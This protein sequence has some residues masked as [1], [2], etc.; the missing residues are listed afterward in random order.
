MLAPRVQDLFRVCPRSGRI[1]GLRWRGRA[2]RWLFPLVGVMALVWHLVRVLPKPGRALYPCQRVAGPLAWAFA[3]YVVSFVTAVVAFHRARRSFRQARYGLAVAC[4]VVA[5]GAAILHLNV[6]SPEAEAAPWIPT[7][8]PNTPIG[9]A[10]GI[11]AGRVVWARDPSACSWNGS[12]GYWWTTNSTDQARVDGLLSH[13]LRRLT[14]DA[15]DAAAWE[16][17]FRSYNATHGNGD[18]GYA[19]GQAV[20][21]KINQ[22]TARS[23]H[24]LNGNTGDQNSINGSPQLILSLLRQLVNEAGV[25][26][27]NLYVYD[28]SRYIADSIFVPCHAEFPQV[29][30]VEVE[31][32]GTEG[33]EAVPPESQWTQNAI[34]YSDPTRA[35]GRHLPPFITSASYLINM[36][37]MKDHGAQ[38]PTLCAKNHYGTIHGLNHGAI[39]PAGM[40]ESNPMVDMHASPYLGERTML[41][42]IDTLY[43]AD[44]PDARPSKWKSQ[45]FGTNWP[46]SVF[47]S[48]DGVAIESVGFDFINAEWGVDPFTDNLMHEAALADNPP[49]GKTYGPKSLG[50]HEHWNNATDMRYSRDLGGPDGIELARVFFPAAP[51]TVLAAPGDGRVDLR[52]SAGFG[53]AAYNV[54]RATSPGGPYTLLAGLAGTTY[55]D[56]GVVNGSAYYYVVSA[57]NDL[58]E[59]AASAEISATPGA[60]VAAINCGGAAVAQFSADS[61]FVG[62]AVG[63]ATTAFIETDGLASAAPQSVYQTERYGNSFRYAFSNLATGVYY[64]VRL[65]LAET[66]WSGVGQRVFHTFVNGVQVLTNFDLVAVTGG[67][68]RAAIR[69]YVVPASGSNTVEVRFTTVADNAK[70][71]G[72]ELLVA[73]PFVQWQMSHFGSVD[74]PEAAAGADPDEDHIPNGDE[75]GAGTNPNSATSGLRVVSATLGEYGIVVTWSTAGG[76]TNVLEAADEPAGPYTNVVG[77]LAIAGGG[78]VITN[79]LDSGSAGP[80][81][82]FYRA[83]LGP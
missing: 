32:G 28:I 8:A 58:G 55:T 64:T 47:L 29:H 30:F 1:V 56:T 2:A 41:F 48:Q 57:T 33:R 79:C 83:R 46:A 20:V 17:L 44:G 78:D 4:A 72:I 82:R 39:T 50:V 75:F 27:T 3:G 10:R 7:D 68:N 54:K 73:P 49:S 9:V 36:A 43:G 42:M 23:G 69:E 6:S 67:K 25:P 31:T 53:A 70:C 45:P 66:Y 14:G 77:C 18:T 63:G 52:W 59:S 65:H 62:G 26:Q 71:S 24:A 11:Q 60:F 13:A 74:V 19:P 22:N 38:G 16:A 81:A 51:G 5:A 15:A 40:G 12:T 80:A 21:I 34:T 76:R 35:C 61:N 37:I